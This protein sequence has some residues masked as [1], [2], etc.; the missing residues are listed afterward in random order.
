VHL[1]STPAFDAG[2][3]LSFAWYMGAAGCLCS[4]LLALLLRQQAL[5]RYRA[6]QHA[7]G[8]MSQ[9]EQ[10]A[11]VIAHTSNAVSIAD[12]DARITWINQGFHTSQ[13]ILLKKSSE[14]T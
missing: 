6:E 11:L 10:M 8:M 7:S 13:V 3:D 4:A 12:K 5:S 14:K 1:N 9:M 2:I